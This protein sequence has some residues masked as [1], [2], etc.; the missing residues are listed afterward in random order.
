MSKLSFEAL[1]VI[2]RLAPSYNLE[3][4]KDHHGKKLHLHGAGKSALR[5][6]RDL[7]DKGLVF[8]TEVVI[9]LHSGHP[10]PDEESISSAEKLMKAAKGLGENDLVIFCLS[11]GASALMEKPIDGIELEE[12]QR[13]Y[14]DL[15][16]SGK[17][18]H[19]INR[20]RKKLSQTKGGKLG[21]LYNPAHVHC[22][23]ESD[24]EGDIVEDVGSSPILGENNGHTYEVILT[25]NHL[26]ETAKNV[27]PHYDF[28]EINLD[29]ENNIQK[30]LELIEDR[31]EL[32]SVGEA[33]VRVHKEGRG[34]RNSHWVA[35]MGIELLQKGYEFEILSIGTDGRDADTE[36]AGAWLDHQVSI[37]ELEKAAVEFDTYTFFKR[38]NRLIQIDET[39]FNLN[40][41]RLIRI[42]SKKG[43]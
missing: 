16:L 32:A 7:K 14:G 23:I 2:N 30:H 35:L 40:D 24:V 28:F 12:L 31:S 36:A 43:Q 4:L 8:E 37:E 29:I 13:I 27:L 17:S 21:D 5:M 6:A 22:F 26:I 1:E 9:G 38:N 25:K 42:H 41:L 19:E 39:G 11:G 3:F 18:I 33:T 34:G 20:E 10:I 15:L